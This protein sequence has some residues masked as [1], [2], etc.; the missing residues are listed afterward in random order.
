MPEVFL[1]LGSNQSPELHIGNAISALR[2]RFGEVRLSP[3]YESEAVGFVG[4]NFLN[5]V[6]RIETALTIGELH[7]ILRDIE[8]ANGRDRAQARFSGR[9]LDIDILTYGDAQGLI[10]GVQLPRDEVFVNA[11]VLKP[12]SDLAPWLRVGDRQQTLAELWQAF[13]L[14]AQRLWQV[15]KD[16]PSQ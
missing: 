8:N 3:I 7:Q 15:N 12:F 2:D 14:G 9:T 10:E 6:A 16:W 4:D 1:G 13:D 11:F 5:L